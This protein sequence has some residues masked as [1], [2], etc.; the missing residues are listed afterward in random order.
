MDLQFD[1][2]NELKNI[3]QNKQIVTKWKD[4]QKNSLVTSL[5]SR[6]LKPLSS[7]S[8]LIKIL[9]VPTHGSFW[10]ATN[11][12]ASFPR[13]DELLQNGEFVFGNGGVGQVVEVGKTVRKAKVGDFVAIFGH[14]GCQ[15]DDCYACRTAQ[16]YVECEYGESATLGQ[17]TYDGTYAEYTLIPEESLE[18]CY[19]YEEKP[20]LTD[21]L[22]MA[23]AFLVADVRNALTRIPNTLSRNR[24]LLISAGLSSHIA[25]KIILDAN[26]AASIFVIEPNNSRLQSLISLDPN[27]ID[28]IDFNSQTLVGDREIKELSLLLGSKMRTHF[29]KKNCNFVIDCASADASSIWFNDRILS[30]DT[31]C[32]FFGFGVKEV[33]ISSKLIQKSGLIIQFSRSPGDSQNQR[34]VIQFLK[35]SSGKSFIEQYF[36][37]KMQHFDSW[38][39]FETYI[40]SHN[41]LNTSHVTIPNCLII[42]IDST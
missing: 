30:H 10:S 1:A 41:K 6:Q 31:M 21:L 15:Y 8:L 39:K 16:R 26:K 37:K 28:G 9:A 36:I 12:R 35:S 17:G 7:N 2:Q 29:D 25:A 4:E 18:V 42:S 34:S 38:E 33:N 5:E 32:I 19:N 23:F 13:L 27:R 14:I 24:V 11:F 22:P 20:H 40:K 3:K